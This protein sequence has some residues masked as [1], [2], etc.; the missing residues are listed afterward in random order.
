MTDRTH[1]K[2]AKDLFEWYLE[3]R[4]EIMIEASLKAES[5]SNSEMHWLQKMGELKQIL[6]LWRMSRIFVAE[7]LPDIAQHTRTILGVA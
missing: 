5:G 3:T 6:S 4:L 7:D 2:D 1:V